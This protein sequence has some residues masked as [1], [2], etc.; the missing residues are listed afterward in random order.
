MPITEP[1]TTGSAPRGSPS[2]RL[3][4][5]F[6]KRAAKSS[7]IFRSTTMRSVD[8]QICPELAKAPNAAAF[9][10]ASRSASSSTTSGALPPSSSTTGFRCFAQVSAMSLPTRVEPVKLTRRTAGW[11]TIAST[12]SAASAGALVT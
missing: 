8:M 4:A 6:A 2:G 12:T 3:R 7:A 1:S 9:T 10:A 5:F 11:A